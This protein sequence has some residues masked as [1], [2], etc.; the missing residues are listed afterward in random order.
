MPILIDGHNLIGQGEIPN[1]HL[2][3]VDDEY[4]LVLI[5]RSYVARK[6]GRRI[7]VVFD[8]GVYSD[9]QSMNGFGVR[10]YFVKPPNDADSELIRR[11]RAIKRRSEWQVVTSDNAVAGEARVR[12]VTVISSQAFAKQLVVQKSPAVAPIDKYR[13]RPLPPDEVEEWMRFLGIDEE[14]A[15]K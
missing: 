9:G 6:P 10:C 2:S 15:T 8:Q 4:R 3:A 13:D 12:G 7:E 1:L 5:L 14:D 11:I